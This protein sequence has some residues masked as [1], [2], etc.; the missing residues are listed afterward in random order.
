MPGKIPQMDWSKPDQS[1]SFKLFKQNMEI[2]CEDEGITDKP[3]KAQKILRGIGDEGL[4]RLNAKLS[5]GKPISG[6]TLAAAVAEGRKHEAIV[7]G[8]KSITSA[9]TQESGAAARMDV[10]AVKSRPSCQPCG[11]CLL[12]HKPRQC[13]AYNDE[14]KACGTLGHWEKCCRKS[15][16]GRKP[17]RNAD[18]RGRRGSGTGSRGNRRP[19]HEIGYTD[20]RDSDQSDPETLGLQQFSSIKISSACLDALRTGVKPET[21]AYVNLDVRIPDIKG[22]HLFE[23]KI[24][25]GASGN[26]LPV[27]TYKQMYGKTATKQRLKPLVNT[28]LTAYNGQRIPCW[29]T[30]IIKCRYKDQ[31]FQDVTFYVVDVPGP[32]VLGLPSCRS[33]KLVTIH[34][35]AQNISTLETKQAKP[36]KYVAD[37][38]RAYPNRFDTIGNLGKPA[39]LHLKE[40]A[41]PFQDPPRKYAIHMKPRLKTE[42]DRIEKM[43]VIRKVTEH[44]DWCSSLAFAEKSD[45]SLRICLDPQKLNKSLKRCPHKKPTIEDINPALARCTVFSK[46][47]AKAGY[48]AIPLEEESQLLTTFRTPFG[49]YC[50][51]RLQFGLA[52]SQDIF[53]SRMDDVLEGLTCTVGIADD[54]IVGGEGDAHHDSN[55]V[56]LMEK[57]GPAGVVFNSTKCL[58]RKPSVPFFGNLYSSRG[59]R[60]DPGKV[61]DI[62]EMPVPQD[63]DDLHRFLGIMTYLSPHIPNY[64][65]EACILRGLLKKDI[66]FEWSED[67]Q[68][69]FEHL[70]TLISSDSTLAY[71][72]PKQPVTLEVDASQKGLG[73]ALLQHGRPVAFASKALSDTQSRYSNIEPEALGLVHGIERFH[74]YLYGR[75]FTAITDHKPLDQEI[76]GDTINQD[77]VHCGIYKPQQLRDLTSSDPVLQQ[78]SEYIWR[79][80][81]AKQHDL[82]APLRQFWSYRDELAMEDG[83][84]FKGKQ[85]VI[86]ETL[87]KNILE[88]LH[89]AHQGI[90]KTRRLARELVYWPNINKDVEDLVSKCSTCQEYRPQ[91]KKEPLIPHEIAK[92]PW[93]KLA[94][95]LFEVNGRMYLVLADYFTKYL[96]VAEMPPP[97]TCKKVMKEIRSA[98]SFFGRPDEI[99]S[100]NGGHYTGA[101]MKTFCSEWS[102]THTTSSP[103]YPQSNGFS[104]AMVDLVKRTIKKCTKTGK[105]L[106]VAMMNLRATP[107]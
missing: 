35:D 103:R 8:H 93:M 47:D 50:W 100:D 23:L 97:V 29:G 13:P 90:E 25:T 58:I 38:M 61:K 4:R 95:D 55:L 37:L 64:S 78:L 49:R 53:Q 91:D 62:A 26:T 88:Q 102:I 68:K 39:K 40:D 22:T 67:H 52:V 15:K 83:I 36:I 94:L 86:P 87:R 56:A 101:E 42:L 34:C 65:A 31:P 71:Y 3:K 2:F 82:P 12:H 45:G 106:D 92:G 105:S 20:E 89:D 10:D 17:Y 19:V 70:K 18:R 46:L 85:V 96:I 66:P 44:T 28:V 7:A 11:N 54:V 72:D 74:T 6:I 104:E 69:Q 43:G 33:M 9:L 48:W 79:G 5:L 30:I 77:L 59:V 41:V 51:T 107:E 98:C 81:P 32:A 21:E 27:R 76:E 73:A 75:F 57:S 60:P 24:D 84:L 14:C 99:I 63:K 1:E 16:N 80:W